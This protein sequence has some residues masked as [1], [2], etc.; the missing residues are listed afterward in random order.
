MINV[1]LFIYIKYIYIYS[2]SDYLIIYF[3]LGAIKIG[4]GKI[5]AI[6]G[7]PWKSKRISNTIKDQNYCVL[8]KQ[9]WL[10]GIN[11]GNGYIRQFVAMP[12][13][14]GYTVEVW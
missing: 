7:K 4:I 12:L 10:D 6:T 13:G 14:Q 8:P 5:N 2:L 1:G 3:Y 11:C 9:P